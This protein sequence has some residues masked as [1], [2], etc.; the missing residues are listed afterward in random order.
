MEGSNE[1]SQEGIEAPTEAGEPAIRVSQ[2][3]VHQRE[4]LPFIHFI[5]HLSQCNCQNYLPRD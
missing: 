3:H 4:E 1:G 2:L 5:H